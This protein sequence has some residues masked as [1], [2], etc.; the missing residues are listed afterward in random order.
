MTWINENIHR[1]NYESIILLFA[2]KWASLHLQDES[3]KT[4][5]V[6]KF[7]IRCTLITGHTRLIKTETCYFFGGADRSVYDKT[8]THYYGFISPPLVLTCAH[9]SMQRLRIPASCV[10]AYCLCIMHLQLVKTPCHT[11]TPTLSWGR[12]EALRC[13][14]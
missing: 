6:I 2:T 12:V 13:D 11:H 3:V 5:R 1:Q 7:I 14:A 8:F 9:T 4:P 10:S